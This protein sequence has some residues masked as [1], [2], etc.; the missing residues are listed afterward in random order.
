MAAGA[1]AGFA[2]GARVLQTKFRTR[3]LGLPVVRRLEEE[4][5]ECREAKSNSACVLLR[6]HGC[7]LEFA[8]V[9][10]WFGL[11]RPV[12]KRELHYDMLFMQHV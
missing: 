12:V 7:F 1:P 5:S 8:H 6:G 10:H 2:G 11:V 3:S 9:L 4:R